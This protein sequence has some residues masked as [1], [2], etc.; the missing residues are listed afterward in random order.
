MTSHPLPRWHS[1]FAAN[2]DVAIATIRARGALESRTIELLRGS[3]DIL[4]IPGRRSITISAGTHRHRP[5]RRRVPHCPAQRPRATHQ[6]D[7]RLVHVSEPV[8]EA[9]EQ[10][11]IHYPDSGVHTARR[12]HADGGTHT[13]TG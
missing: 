12:T 5:R 1:I 8:R 4:L 3:V 9:L 7:L 10:G 6:G 11:Q 2:V 13:D